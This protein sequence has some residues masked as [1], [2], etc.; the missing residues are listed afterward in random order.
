MLTKIL[1]IVR[2]KLMKIPRFST[3]ISNSRGKFLPS[4]F[5][6][7]FSSAYYRCPRWW[8]SFSPLDSEKSTSLISKSTVLSAFLFFCDR[9]MQS[10]LSSLISTWLFVGTKYDGKERWKI[11]RRKAS[12]SFFHPFKKFRGKFY[13]A[14]LVFDFVKSLSR[15]LQ[16]F[17][18]FQRN[19]LSG[20]KYFCWFRFFLKFPSWF[21]FFLLA[22]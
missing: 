3:M 15:F 4:R 16:A 20:G 18:V 1:S 10:N 9:L 2:V 21:I 19:I 22:F 12:Q 8:R 13:K 11:S 5:R 17:H 14:N 7:C 6:N